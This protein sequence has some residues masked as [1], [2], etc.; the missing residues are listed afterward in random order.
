MKT[1][2]LRLVAAAVILF[3][4][5]QLVPYG[6]DHTNPPVRQEVKWN[7]SQTHDLAVRACYDCHSNK[8]TWP[9]YSNVAPVSWLIQHDVDEARQK[10]NFTDMA[11]SQYGGDRAAQDIL[12]GSMPRWYFTLIHPE[13]KLSQAEKDALAKGM[14][15]SLGSK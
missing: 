8:T 1:V 4:L 11:G 15:T 2:I 7:S 5:I 9:W 13:A 6:R 12:D 10:L 14:Q 3:L